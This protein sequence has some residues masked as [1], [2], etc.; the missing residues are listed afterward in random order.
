MFNNSGAARST[1]EGA[2][3]VTAATLLPQDMTW[4]DPQP[5]QKIHRGWREDF[6]PAD[7]ARRR[8]RGY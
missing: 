8:C 3:K 7:V 4:R 2:L 1:G 5:L 6:M